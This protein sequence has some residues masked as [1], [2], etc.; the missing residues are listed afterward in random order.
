MAQKDYKK[1][2]EDRLC[3]IKFASTNQNF[4]GV[5]SSKDVQIFEQK[6]ENIVQQFGSPD[7]GKS[8]SQ[9]FKLKVV[10]EVLTQIKLDQLQSFEW[11]KFK[12]QLYIAAA[13]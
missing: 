3:E 6:Q 1:E 7:D 9:K 13:H 11:A 2:R 5:L 8:L 12:H 4:L 10:V